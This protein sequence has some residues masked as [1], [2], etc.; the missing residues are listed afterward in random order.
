MTRALL[1]STFAGLALLAVAVMASPQPAPRGT[2]Q[3]AHTV[4]VHIDATNYRPKTVTVGVGDTVVWV[5]DDIYVH[6]ATGNAGQFDSKDIKP[7]G[8][9]KYVPRTAGLFGY[10]CTYH[11]TMKGTLRV[12]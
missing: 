4:V 10:H 7:G 2:P 12:R 1:P 11:A 8:S 3:A 6:T 5:N 9:W